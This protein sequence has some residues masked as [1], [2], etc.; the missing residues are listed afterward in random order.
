MAIKHS[1]NAWAKALGMENRTLERQL[2][3]AGF[4]K[5]SSGWGDVSAKYIQAAILGDEQAEKVRNLRLDA[6]EK[7][8]DKAE[9][10]GLIQSREGIERELWDNGLGKVRDALLDW[11]KQA[12]MKIKAMMEAAGCHA[13]LIEHVNATAYDAIRDPL[14]KLNAELKTK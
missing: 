7:E 4:E 5:P 8:R 13:D 9:A 1:I 10:H 11:P 3:R 6:D 14:E 12:G 2:V